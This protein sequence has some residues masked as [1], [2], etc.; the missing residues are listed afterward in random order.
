MSIE[1]YTLD[2]DN[3]LVKALGVKDVVATI[4]SRGNKIVDVRLEFRGAHSM[5]E[6]IKTEPLFAYKEEICGPIMGFGFKSNKEY[7][8]TVGLLPDQ[9]TILSILSEST[10]KALETLLQAATHPAFLELTSYRLL[11]VMQQVTPKTQWGMTTSYYKE[12]EH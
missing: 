8:F 3:F 12:L 6:K 11:S 1:E 2:V 4:I 7:I 10:D 9:I 5:W